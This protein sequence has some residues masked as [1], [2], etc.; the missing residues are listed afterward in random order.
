MKKDNST[1][2]TRYTYDRHGFYF[3]I[4]ETRDEF[5]AW[6]GLDR[7]GIMSFCFGQSKASTSRE[8]FLDLLEG[9]AVEEIAMFL[10]EYDEIGYSHPEILDDYECALDFVTAR[11]QFGEDRSKLVQEFLAK[12]KKVDETRGEFCDRLKALKQLYA[13]ETGY[14]F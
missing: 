1:K 6:I 8:G 2:I 4:V 3:E 11:A 10:M 13:D 12:G 5:D 9:N 7:Y 14:W